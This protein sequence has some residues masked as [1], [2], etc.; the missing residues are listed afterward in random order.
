MGILFFNADFFL[1]SSPELSYVIP[2]SQG[3]ELNLMA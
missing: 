2:A 3:A 1:P